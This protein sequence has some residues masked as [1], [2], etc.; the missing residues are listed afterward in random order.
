M[1]A[2][3]KFAFIRK[4]IPKKYVQ[5]RYSPLELKRI[6]LKYSPKKATIAMSTNLNEMGSNELGITSDDFIKLI[7]EAESTFGV[8][9]PDDKITL[10]RNVGQLDKLIR[11]E[12]KQGAGK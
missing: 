10:L 2:L 7:M 1:K 4:G 6:I 3:E 8:R 5:K 11:S 9:L 12:L